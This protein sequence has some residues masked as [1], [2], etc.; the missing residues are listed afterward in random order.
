VTATVVV[1]FFFG[2]VAT[3]KVALVSYRHLLL[4]GFVVAKKA[5]PT[6]Y[7]CLYL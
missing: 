6:Y 5:M 3:Q 4:F 2:F 7:C 1:A